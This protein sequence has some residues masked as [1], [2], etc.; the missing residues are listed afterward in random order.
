MV[1]FAIAHTYGAPMSGL[2]SKY[3]SQPSS[4]EDVS[5][6]NV[7]LTEAE[8]Y[9]TTLAYQAAVPASKCYE[10]YD[11]I[12]RKRL[13]AM[14]EP[15]IAAHFCQILA[16]LVRVLVV[17]DKYC[18]SILQHKTRC[19][20]LETLPDCWTSRQIL[21]VI[22]DLLSLS[23]PTNDFT[24][25]ITDSIVLRSALYSDDDQMEA[26]IRKHPAVAQ[27][28]M[29]IQLKQ[30]QQSQDLVSKTFCSWIE[31]RRPV[32]SSEKTSK[33]HGTRTT[34]NSCGYVDTLVP[35]P[36]II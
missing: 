16:L 20:I 10:R 22:N 30:G 15:A 27:R 24:S 18:L 8:Q 1:E 3:C 29:S 36:T 34:C 32:E 26:I 31:C 12:S 19:L 13:K 23:D 21:P 28:Y 17:A 14:V 5:L 4:G 33:L 9:T 35:L 6:G 7:K 11:K 2:V 25:Q